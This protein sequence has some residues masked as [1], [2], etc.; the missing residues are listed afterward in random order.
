MSD[1]YLYVYDLSQGL[2]SQL[3]HMFI[4]KHLDGIW[5]TAIVAFG[6]EWF[7]GGSGIE[8]CMPVNE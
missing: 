2:A 6:R 4:G 8:D 7:F 3:A 1:V 5:H